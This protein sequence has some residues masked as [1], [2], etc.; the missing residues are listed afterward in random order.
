ME[1]RVQLELLSSFLP[2]TSHYGIVCEL[3]HLHLNAERP[4]IEIKDGTQSL[5]CWQMTLQVLLTELSSKDLLCM[6]S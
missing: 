4:G 5:N 2:L 3:G 1:A 6:N